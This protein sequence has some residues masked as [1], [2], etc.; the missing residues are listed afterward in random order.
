MR[1]NPSLLATRDWLLATARLKAS[2]LPTAA[3]EADF[4]ASAASGPFS[5]ASP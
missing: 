2:G 4:M 3:N 5:S 1:L